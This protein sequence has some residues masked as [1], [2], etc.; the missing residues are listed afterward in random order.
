VESIQDVAPD[1]RKHSRID[2]ETQVSIRSIYFASRMIGW[3]EDISRGGFKVRA[4]IPLNFIGLFNEGDPVFF[5]THEDFFK[6]RGK[7]RIQ[8]TSSEKGE[9]GVKFDELEYKS[10]KSLEAFLK[11]FP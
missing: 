7:G 3:I 4:G 11:M 10:R 8:W 1:K 5:E 6:L 2:L 9:A